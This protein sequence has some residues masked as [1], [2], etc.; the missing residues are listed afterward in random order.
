MVNAFGPF[1]ETVHL[2]TEKFNN[3]KTMHACSPNDN[4]DGVR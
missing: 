4:K 1:N 2:K 3:T